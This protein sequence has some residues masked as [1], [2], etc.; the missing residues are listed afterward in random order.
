MQLPVNPFKRALQQGQTQ[1]G[2]WL[3]LG[4]PYCAE[5]AAG[6]GYDWLLVDGEHAP[7]DILTFL[8]QLQAVAPYPSH[9]I[10]RPVEGTPALIKQLLDIGAQTLLIPMVESA[11]QAA[12]LVAATRYPPR[13]MRGVGASLARASRWGRVDGYLE[14]AEDEL[15]LLLQVETRKGLDNLDAITRVEGVDGVFIGP[16]DL[17]ASMGHLGNPGHPEVQAAIESGIRRIRALGKAAG[18]LAS[19]EESARN[20][21]RW[22]ANF[23]AVAVDTTLLCRALADAVSPFKDVMSG[24][25]GSGY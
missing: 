4:N 2:L 3:S 8:S 24:P 15:C 1:I 9:P 18:I 5:L 10:V 16:V 7:N 21:I 25:R 6:A 12:A 17:S 11:E 14:R 19:G 22:G 23:V 13:G 20:Y